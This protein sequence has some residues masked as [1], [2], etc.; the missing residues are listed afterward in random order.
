MSLSQT[1]IEVIA[2]IAGIIA[3]AYVAN[4]FATNISSGV[5]SAEASAGQ[6][7]SSAASSVGTG[8]A[9]GAG[10]ALLLLPLLLL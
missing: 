8:V 1:D 5:N 6:G 10:G 9:V 4:N 2:V 3:V 7:I